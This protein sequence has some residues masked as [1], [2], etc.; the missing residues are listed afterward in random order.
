MAFVLASSQPGYEKITTRLMSETGEQFICFTNHEDLTLEALNIIKPAYIFFPHWSFIIP[1]EIYNNYECVMFHMA[2]L[3]WGRGGSP[4]QN[5]IARGIYETQ[6]TAFRCEKGLD[7]GQIYCKRPLSLFGTAE[8]IYMRAAGVIEDMIKWII[9][10][11]PESVPQQGEGCYF[12][13]RKPEEGNIAELDSL[14][15]LFDYI[16]MLDAEG[17][18]RAFLETRHFRLEFERASL[19]QDHIKADVIIHKK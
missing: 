17:Y 7:T 15:K 2:D 18:P 6:I 12:M 9:A 8:E 3:P 4:L 16:R 5:L 11:Q 14:E 13:R 10:H 19:K 1:E